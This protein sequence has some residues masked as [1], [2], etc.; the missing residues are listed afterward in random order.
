MKYKDWLNEWLNNYIK[1]TAKSATED[2]YTR[3]I[4]NHIAPKL[5]ELDMDE[6]TP[7]ILQHYIIELIERGNNKK[8]TGLAS[9]TVNSIINV[10]Q[11][12]IRVAFNLGITKVNSATDL[13]HPRTT[14]KKVDCFSSGDQSRIVCEILNG[15]KPHLF[16]IVLCLYT[17]LR[18]GELLALT[19]N[20][21]DLQSGILNVNKSCHY[22]KDKSGIFGMIVEAPKTQS[23]YRQIPLPKQLLQIIKNY[24]KQSDCE[25]VV[26]KNGRPISTRTY[27]RNFEVLLDDL[28]IPHKGFHALRH[29]FATRAIEC[30]MDVKTLSEILGHKNATITLNRYT[31]SLLEHKKNMMNLVGKLL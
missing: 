20:D 24:K 3:I 31:H 18:I 30:G 1:L 19:W 25:Y 11:N 15:N 9:N 17:G 8:N 14:E 2:K 5:G 26:S 13:Q 6:L 21:L 23:S 12:S 4:K 10:L 27:Q 22:G 7:M 28:H 16:G 29:T